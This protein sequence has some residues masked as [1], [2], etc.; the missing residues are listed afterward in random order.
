MDLDTI[1]AHI[2]LMCAAAASPECCRIA[3]DE[4]AIR[5]RVRNPAEVDWQR[6]KSQ[7]LRGAWK[8]SDDGQFWQQDGLRRTFEKQ[9]AYSELQRERAN[10]RYGKDAEATPEQLPDSCRNSAEQLPEVLRE[11][12]FAFASTK[13]SI[14]S[15]AKPSDDSALNAALQ[16]VWQYYIQQTGRNSKTYEFTEPRKK[17][18][19]LRLKDCLRKTEGDLDRATQ[20]MMAAIDAMCASDW[21]MGRDKKTDGKKYCDWIDNLFDAYEQMEGWWNK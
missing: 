9:S 21:H 1:G 18:G 8:I 14:S 16:T 3:A 17:K 11:S 7:L 19:L 13:L 15:K 20:L 4:R 10:K 6:I 5:N 12:C 2:L